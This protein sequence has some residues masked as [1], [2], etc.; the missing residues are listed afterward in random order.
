MATPPNRSVSDIPREQSQDAWT[1]QEKADLKAMRRLLLKKLNEESSKGKVLRFFHGCDESL[2]EIFRDEK[3]VVNCSERVIAVLRANYSQNGQEKTMAVPSPQTSPVPFQIEENVI[4]CHNQTFAQ[5]LLQ[6]FQ[7]FFANTS[8]N[9]LPTLKTLLLQ[10]LRTNIGV[11]T[12]CEKSRFSFSHDNREISGVDAQNFLLNIFPYFRQAVTLKNLHLSSLHRIFDDIQLTVLPLRQEQ[13]NSEVANNYENQMRQVLKTKESLHLFKLL[14]NKCLSF[15]EFREQAFPEF[16]GQ[17][18]VGFDQFKLAVRFSPQRYEGLTSELEKSILQTSGMKMLTDKLQ[19]LTEAQQR[20]EFLEDFHKALE[21]SD[22]AMVEA[23]TVTYFETNSEAQEAVKAVIEKI[24]ED[25]TV[26]A[27]LFPPPQT[28]ELPRKRGRPR[29]WRKPTAASVSPARLETNKVNDD[30]R[31]KGCE[32]NNI[33]YKIFVKKL[34]DETSTRR[35]Q[36]KPH[37]IS[38]LNKEIDMD[39]FLKETNL[40]DSKTRSNESNMRNLRYAFPE[41][42]DLFKEKTITLKDLNWSFADISYDSARE[43]FS[44]KSESRRNSSE[45]RSET[46]EVAV[47]S[48]PIINTTSLQTE[49]NNALPLDFRLLA[50]WQIEAFGKKR[51]LNVFFTSN[52]AIFVPDP[53]ISLDG[54]TEGFHFKNKLFPDGKSGKLWFPGS[55]ISQGIFFNT[56]ET[57]RDFED[58]FLNKHSVSEKVLLVERGVFQELSF[59]YQMIPGTSYD[60]LPKIILPE[61]DILNQE[62]LCSTLLK[63]SFGTVE[64]MLFRGYIGQFSSQHLNGV[65]LSEFLIISRTD[66]YQSLRDSM[67]VGEEVEIRICRINQKTKLKLICPIECDDQ[68]E[69]LRVR[70]PEMRMANILETQDAISASFLDSLN[71]NIPVAIPKSQWSN[72]FAFTEQSIGSQISVWVKKIKLKVEC[73]AKYSTKLGASSFY[74]YYFYRDKEDLQTDVN[75]KLEVYVVLCKD[76]EESP[77]EKYNMEA[78]VYIEQLTDDVHSVRLFMKG[79]SKT[80]K[81]EKVRL[82]QEAKY[83]FQ[84][85]Q[86]RESVLTRVD[87]LTKAIEHR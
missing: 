41:F 1:E 53:T 37:F 4:Q 42:L 46:A 17:L 45:Q 87:I 72:F 3:L 23:F 22:Q 76:E 31:R 18:S 15:T 19:T 6:A 38:L 71:K 85:H 82:F 60:L 11:K 30:P 73:V 34:S 49:T 44:L 77:T 10:L 20:R 50:S 61:R 78:G 14:M 27:E 63:E 51:M 36:I 9:Q 67:F 2:R 64:R 24:G 8:S 35:S 16:L 48:G 59:Q 69:E 57:L 55:N 13:L 28:E 56:L 83:V 7:S 21:S 39:T 26:P 33:V 70:R 58:L 80:L 5:T 65:L 74:A 66:E 40:I 75:Q 43:R 29:G 52:H 32:V 84:A 62:N 47:V 54:L 25:Q 81:T 86:N 12:F 79:D 68:P